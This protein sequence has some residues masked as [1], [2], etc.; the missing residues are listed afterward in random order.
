MIRL[1]AKSLFSY[2]LY[3][4]C[5][6]CY[7]C[8]SNDLSKEE[9]NLVGAWE[10][11]IAPSADGSKTYS[12]I[13]LGKDR[14]GFKGLLNKRDSEL[15]FPSFLSH[16]INHWM[17]KKDTLIVTYTF[18]EGVISIPG[19]EDQEYDAFQEKEYL[20]LKETGEE[21]FIADS[22]HP[23]IPFKSEQRYKR[24]DRAGNI[25]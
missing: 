5:L 20:I 17:I 15:T 12:Y 24:R 22:Y 14:L 2:S 9:K 3:L 18:E 4:V 19:K 25:D 10:Y 21:Y 16:D 6:L 23:E 8:S 7:S 11:E 1:N 13:R